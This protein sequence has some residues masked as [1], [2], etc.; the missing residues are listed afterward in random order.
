MPTRREKQRKGEE[1]ERERERDRG[2]KR[3][4]YII[5]I[6][7]VVNFAEKSRYVDIRDKYGE[8]RKE[9]KRTTRSLFRPVFKAAS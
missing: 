1:R 8:I 4:R 2:W 3:R 5:L 6:K 9:R 7:P